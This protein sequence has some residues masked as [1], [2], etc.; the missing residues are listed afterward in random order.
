MAHVL[1]P[2][3]LPEI[4]PSTHLNYPVSI[5]RKWHGN[6]YRSLTRYRSET[7][8][9]ISPEF[10]APFARIDYVSRDLFHLY[11]HRRTGEWHVMN[12]RVVLAEALARIET[13]P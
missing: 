7:P 8:S 5:H 9:S 1:T 13:D 3:Y 6:K 4:R 2:R 12:K 11:W 10:D